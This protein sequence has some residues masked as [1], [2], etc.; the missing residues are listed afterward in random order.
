MITDINKLKLAKKDIK[1]FVG[2][3]ILSILFYNTCYCAAIQL[4]SLSVAAVLLY[5]SPIFVTLFS[6]PIF[7]EKITRVKL[8]AIL[9]SV[10]GCAL[11]SGLLSNTKVDISI[12]GIFLGV[13]AA[14]GYAFYGILAKILIKKYHSLTILFYS[15]LFASIGGLFAC[16]IKGI[17]GI[18]MNAPISIIAIIITALLC[19][20]IPYILFTT[21]L[22]HIKASKVSIIASIEPVVATLIGFIAFDESITFVN[23]LGIA[24]VLFA[25]RILSKES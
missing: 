22:K 14:I 6:V 23:I 10:I 19:N 11:V 4:T 25:I 5:T 13:C 15:F 18:A 1:W 7:K 9:F 2:T 20:I 3:G 8:L 24:C 17:I 12:K 21:A 16:D